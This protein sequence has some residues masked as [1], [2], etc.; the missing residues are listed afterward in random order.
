MGTLV[1]GQIRR[2]F[3]SEGTSRRRDRNRLE[4]S[5]YDVIYAILRDAERPETKYM[6]LQAL[7]VKIVRLYHAPLHR[8][9][10]DTDDQERSVDETPSLDHV[11]RRC[12]RQEPRT[13]NEIRDME[14]NL[15]KSKPAI[16]RA[17]QNF[18][19]TKYNTITPDTDSIR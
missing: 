19:M 1:K 18:M 9:L 10:L 17:F 15:Q 8:L 3:I 12:E 14:R 6:T 7:K 5:Y 16:V 2:L 4:N 13:V 11:L